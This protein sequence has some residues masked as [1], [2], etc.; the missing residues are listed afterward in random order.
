M[1]WSIPL[2][3]LA[4]LLSRQL[5]MVLAHLVYA[6]EGGHWALRQNAWLEIA[7]HRGGRA[8]SLTVW[9]SLLA[10]TAW[11][12]RR[13]DAARWTRPAAG[14]LLATLLSSV[15]VAWLKSITQVDCPWDLQAFGGAR[16][17]IPLFAARP[18]GLGNPAC[19]PAAHAASGYAWVALYFFLAQVRPSWR[20]LG[21]AT[22]MAAGMLFGI[23]QQ[24]RGAHFL[25]H[26]IASL[27]LCWGIA[28]LVDRIM[29]AHA[30]NTGKPV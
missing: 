13:S 20:W 23:A 18:A 14:L 9:L 2:L 4:W 15:L 12:W 8:A 29:A 30:G 25:S 3:A 17:F 21:L 11:H 19:F 22:G 10:A 7:M 5:D 1:R 24:L 27:T 6:S 28:L 16:P 26:D